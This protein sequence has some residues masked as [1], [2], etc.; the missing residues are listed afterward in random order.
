MVAICCFAA[1]PRCW[2]N[3]LQAAPTASSAFPPKS[4]YTALSQPCV[5]VKCSAYPTDRYSPSHLH[6][7]AHA[8]QMPYALNL[9]AQH[10]E[11]KNWQG[12]GEP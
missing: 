12:G 3:Q 8:S 9:F 7:K 10:L 6:P 5:C 2:L 4:T 1:L 11:L